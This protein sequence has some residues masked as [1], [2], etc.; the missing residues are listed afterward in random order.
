MDRIVTVR[1]FQSAL[2][3]RDLL[4]FHLLVRD[5]N[6]QSPGFSMTPK[7]FVTHFCETVAPP[8]PFYEDQLAND[9]MVAELEILLLATGIDRKRVDIAGLDGGFLVGPEYA[10]PLFRTGGEFW[11]Q[12]AWT[13]LKVG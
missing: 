1:K 8:S 9:G 5:D 11:F 7:P 6:P 12:V 10:D 3:G 2:D 13:A 4:E